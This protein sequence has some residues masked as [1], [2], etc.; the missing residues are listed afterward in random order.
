MT[1]RVAAA[2]VTG[3][4]HAERGE[5]GQDAV[6]VETFHASDGQTVLGIF[7]AD[8]AGSAPFGGEGAACAV[9]AS[10]TYWRDFFAS[11][12]STVD[13]EALGTS[14]LR[15]RASLHDLAARSERD[16]REFA[17]TYLATLASLDGLV[18]LHIGDGGIIADFGNGYV[19]VSAPTNGEYANTTYFVTDPEEQLVGDSI[20]HSKPACR[21]AVFTDGLQPFTLDA[22]GKDAN[23]AFFDRRFQTLEL[24]GEEHVPALNDAL[25]GF[26]NLDMIRRHVSDDM[27]L[28]LATSRRG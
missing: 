8:G 21:L 1:W 13:A 9:A 28:V 2:S 22:L 6:Q 20:W 12:G 5:Q 26:L 18:T 11:N 15:L 25:A 19:V 3:T 14:L 17:C 7:A 4:S 16:V 10:V 23:P 24:A 27:T